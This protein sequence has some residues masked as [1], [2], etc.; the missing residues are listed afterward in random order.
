MIVELTNP[1]DPRYLLVDELPD[2]VTLGDLEARRYGPLLLFAPG[3]VDAAYPQ[4]DGGGT[5]WI[6]PS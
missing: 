4:P 6:R 1:T 5:D 3:P 2:R